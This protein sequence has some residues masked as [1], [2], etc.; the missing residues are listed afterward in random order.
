MYRLCTYA[1]YKPVKKYYINYFIQT[2]AAALGC[3]AAYGA[4]RCIP[5]D[6]IAGL[7]AAGAVSAVIFFAVVLIF[8]GRSR[9]FKA[10]LRIEKIPIPV[11]HM[12]MDAAV[13]VFARHKDN[14]DFVYVVCK[15]GTVVK[16][17]VIFGEQK[18]LAFENSA[19]SVPSDYDSFLR[20]QFGDYIT[21]PPENERSGHD[22]RMGDIEWRV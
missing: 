17:D 15:G 6:G 3:F 12:L 1:L 8:Y 11:R 13:W 5:L 14:T 4:S 22:K 20:Q 16:R 9:V 19:Y 10:L 18:T 7:L 21:P 2:G